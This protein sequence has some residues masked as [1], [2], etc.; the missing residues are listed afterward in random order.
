[1]FNSTLTEIKN[2]NSVGY[3]QIIDLMWKSI[4]YSSLDIN[5]KKI[6]SIEQR[7]AVNLAGDNNLIISSI[8]GSGKT[9]TILSIVEKYNNRKFLILT[10][11][12]KLKFETREK[13]KQMNLNNTIVESYHSF[14]YNYYYDM[15]YNDYG[16]WKVIINNMKPKKIFHFDTIIFD[17]EQ[18]KTILYYQLSLKI[19]KDAKERVAGTPSIILFGDPYQN[20]FA[21]KGSDARFL[22]LGDK[23]FD[24]INKLP[25]KKLT[26]STTYR[27]TKNISNF[28]NYAMKGTGLP[29]IHSMKEDGEKPTYMVVNLFNNDIYKYIINL[30][31]TYKEDEILILSPSV[32]NKPLIRLINQLSD[33]GVNLFVTDSDATQDIDQKLVKGKLMVSTI[34]KQK[35]SERNI[36]IFYC[37]DEPYFK[38]YAKDENPLLCSNPLYVALSRAKKKLI[39]INNKSSKTMKFIKKNELK[40]FVDMVGGECID[41]NKE[42][43]NK[44]DSNEIYTSPTEL[45]KYQDINT[46]NYAFENFIKIKQLT[47][48]GKIIDI[49]SSVDNEFVADINGTIPIIYA[50][51]KATG[52]CKIFDKLETEAWVEY[53]IYSNKKEKEKILGNIS[54][55][56]DEAVNMIRTITDTDERERIAE[57]VFLGSE[58]R[59]QN[60]SVTNP[61]YIILMMRLI[62]IDG[63]NIENITL[64]T[65][66]LTALKTNLIFRIRQIN[67]FD[68]LKDSIEELADRI[69][70]KI[71]KN[72][73]SEIKI[74]WSSNN[75]HM[76]GFID[77]VD[78]KNKIV[79]ELKMTSSLNI[80]H[81]IQLAMYSIFTKGEGADGWKYILFNIKTEESYEVECKD[82][83]GLIKYL[84]NEKYKKNKLITDD[85]WLNEINKIKNKYFF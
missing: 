9:T 70:N 84:I 73:D 71:D 24:A 68:W 61:F 3:N 77:K 41:G 50:E 53:Y 37:F 51:Y 49:P 47:K 63:Y 14:A 66:W 28:I 78:R 44:E 56:V 72:S 35:G 48:I 81:F 46:F 25:W 4:L 18:D 32:K 36:V 22:T 31:Q 19:I 17:E 58:K 38:Y 67:K 34:H 39:L 79:Y 23:T 33:Y 1:M 43:E 13:A 5:S 10:Y 52:K 8:A 15:A 54:V 75:A 42:D 6:L 12:K 20:I 7:N 80:E 85:E 55:N 16:L 2:I 69:N 21:F 62:H 59:L 30:L 74:E 65:I 45:L 57:I 76:I 40:E 29:K 27:M 64:L 83:D 26:F 60:I 11:N 82:P